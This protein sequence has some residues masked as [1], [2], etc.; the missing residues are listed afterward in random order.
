MIEWVQ[1]NDVWSDMDY[2][3]KGSTEKAF[4][5]GRSAFQLM[6]ATFG[7]QLSETDLEYGILPP[8]MYDTSVQE[9]YITTLGNPYTMYS[10]SGGTKDGERAAAVLQTMGYYG[11]SLTTPAI[12]EVTFKGKFSKDPNAIEMFNVIRESIGFDLG[13]LY[14]KELNGMCDLPTM[15]AIS[16]G[17]QWST[18]ANN[19]FAKKTMQTK[20][21]RL[22]KSLDTVVN[23]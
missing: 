16:K 14:S 6:R 1:S 3:A 8:P 7:F 12:F 23:S 19:A 11:Y 15:N 9:E 10:L 13:I 21:D 17:Q 4:R 2:G 20:L 22:N 5:E 18:V